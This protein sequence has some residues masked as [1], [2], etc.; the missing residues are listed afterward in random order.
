MSDCVDVTTRAANVE[1][2]KLCS[3]YRIM[4]CSK[5]LTMAGSGISPKHIR[6]KLA[7]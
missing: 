3:A 1:A 2:L 6:K 5:A 4:D 7:E